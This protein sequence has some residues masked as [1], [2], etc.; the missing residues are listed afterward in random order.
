MT[1][2]K[3]QTTLST[4]T[5][6]MGSDELSLQVL[7]STMNQND[8]KLLDKM[9]LDSDAIIIN[10][11]DKH[12]YEEITKNKHNYKMY[13]FKERGIGLSRNTAL[14][15][16][17][18]EYALL[19]DDD[20]I[21]VE[22]YA[23]IVTEQFQKYPKADLIIFNLEEDIPTRYIIKKPF[24]VTKVNYMRFGA[25][26]IALKP[27]SIKQ[28]GISFHL[29]FGGGTPHSNG[30]DTIFLKDCLDKNLN[31]IAVPI[32]IAKLTEERESTWFNGF[33]EKYYSD[34]GA[35]FKKLSPKFYLFLIVQFV[36]RKYKN[37][38][39][40]PLRREQ[41]RYMMA[42]ARRFK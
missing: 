21:Y 40:M 37:D 27:N 35:L 10:Q 32:T 34:R 25:A 23:E 20:M 7:V 6:K 2:K 28:S 42:G 19:A 12:G 4:I 13:T 11:S 36:V 30:E 9:K 33:N 41:I 15:R 24:K 22:K 29:L 16:S 26:R 17:T 38:G 14:M 18:T 39:N 31:I 8:F 1:L 3:L 5:K